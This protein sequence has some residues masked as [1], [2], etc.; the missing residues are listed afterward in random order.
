MKNNKKEI[1]SKRTDNEIEIIEI[2][3]SLSQCNPAYY[4]DYWNRVY[5]KLLYCAMKCIGITT[6]IYIDLLYINYT[7]ME[8]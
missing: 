1:F 6:C 7:Y 2:G 5:G 3:D 4:N 8:D